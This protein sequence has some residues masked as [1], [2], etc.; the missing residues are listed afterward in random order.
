MSIAQEVFAPQK[1]LSMSHFFTICFPSILQMKM[2]KT[3]KCG[4]KIII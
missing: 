4:A 1:R 3:Q 2:K